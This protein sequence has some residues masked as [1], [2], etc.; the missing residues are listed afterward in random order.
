MQLHLTGKPGSGQ[1]VSE[2]ILG[3]NIEM[4]LG[5]ANGL[6]SERLRN[7]KFLG[8]AHPMTGIAPHWLGTTYGAAACELTPFAGLNGSEAQLVRV[9]GPTGGCHLVQNK[10]QVRAGEELEVEIWA[11]AWHEPVTLRVSLQPLEARAQTYD[12]QEVVI[13]KPYFAR[14]TLPL[15][16]PRNDDE[17]R[18]HLLIV[19]N[20]EVWFDQ[21]HLRPK[22]EPHLCTKVIDTMAGMSIPTLRFPGG[23][24]VNAYHWKHGT[25]PVHLRP[26]ALDPA[27]HHD[28]YLNYDFGLDE[29]LRIC[30][31]QKI[32]PAITLNPATDT[33]DDAEGLAR[34]C[35][36]WF[37]TAGMKPPL[38]YWHVANH[39]YSRTTAHMTPDMYAGVVRNFVP[40]VKAAYP[41]NRI[42]GVMSAGELDA[43]AKDAPWREKLFEVADLI[44]VIAVQIYG[45]CDPLAAPD[46]QL[47]SV[48]EALVGIEPKIKAFIAL[49]RSRGVRWN[50]EIAE[51]NWWMQASHWDGRE[52]E[53]PPTVLHG[54]YISGM[55]HRFAALAPDLEVAHFYNLVNCMGILNHKGAEIEVTDAVSIFNLYRPA[56]PGRFMP[57]ELEGGASTVEALGLENDEG[58]FIFLTNRS[59]SESAQVSLDGFASAGAS[60]TGFQGEAPTGRFK[61]INP[62]I[63]KNTADVPPLS[64]VRIKA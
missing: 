40:R 43:D 57:L 56:L 38:I 45:G 33:P 64:I 54:L 30:A 5:T 4:C 46:D 7:P 44:D 60:A 58:R 15:K 52:F 9:F 36:N 63:T 53:E 14:Y 61:A 10:V 1:V 39:P 13:D 27:F 51:W 50:V 42:V 22:G 49:C 18:L 16:A 8:P 20:G 24:I 29:Y 62:K 59:L 34:Y 23:I 31:D 41:K 12:K 32:V 17:A 19:G 48:T 55:I 3:H 28:W 35:E 37:R 21:V 47:K 11:R 26:S 6:L 25:G 2:L